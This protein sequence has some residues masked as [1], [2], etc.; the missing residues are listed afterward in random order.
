LAGDEQQ[1]AGSDEAD[2]IGNGGCRLMQDDALCRQ[3]LF[4]RTS[5]VSSS[6]HDGKFTIDRRGAIAHCFA[7]RATTCKR[8]V[9]AEIRFDIRV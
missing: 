4:H 5:H 8:V 1:V 7:H 9:V 6:V 2:I 3:F